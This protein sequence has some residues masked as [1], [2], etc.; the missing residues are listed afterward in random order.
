MT[1]RLKMLHGRHLQSYVQ[2]SCPLSL[3]PRPI[4]VHWTAL[5]GPSLL[6]LGTKL[7][8]NV[9]K[10]FVV[11]T[12]STLHK[13]QGKL[14]GVPFNHWNTYYKH[15]GRA[16]E[17]TVTTFANHNGTSSGSFPPHADQH[18]PVSKE[19]DR[20]PN[21][22]MSKL[23]MRK[24]SSSE[25]LD[26]LTQCLAQVHAHWTIAVLACHNRGSKGRDQGTE[27]A[28]DSLLIQQY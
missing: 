20:I 6:E 19:C 21:Y 10:G 22:M 15:G 24:E 25:N 7:V 9:M 26:G 8:P 5:S 2:L 16:W 3:V 1:A 27:I 28:P 13:R 4:R 14:Q 23:V 11:L 12:N 17:V 18:H